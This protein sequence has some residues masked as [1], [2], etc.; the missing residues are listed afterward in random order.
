[1]TLPRMFRMKFFPGRI[2]VGELNP[3]PS[4]DGQFAR[5]QVLPFR[6]ESDSA[7]KKL[8]TMRKKL[9]RNPL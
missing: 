5:S 3:K 1:M 6:T 7:P 9:S 4:G 2:Q 8:L